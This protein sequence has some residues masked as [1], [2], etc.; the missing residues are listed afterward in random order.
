MEQN[1]ADLAVEAFGCNYMRSKVLFLFFVCFVLLLLIFQVSECL[2]DIIYRP[3]HLYSRFPKR[4]SSMWN[5]INL[6]T[7]TSWLGI[8]LSM[9]AVFIFCKISVFIGSKFGL[10]TNKDYLVLFPFR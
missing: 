10:K 7:P 3:Q 2:P 9:T 6:F 5:F 4:V 1:I 8:F